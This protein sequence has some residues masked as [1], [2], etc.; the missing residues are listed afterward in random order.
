M[1]VLHT[2]LFTQHRHLIVN[3]SIYRLLYVHNHNACMVLV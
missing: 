3:G 2:A 1:D